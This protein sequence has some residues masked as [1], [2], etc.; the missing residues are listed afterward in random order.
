MTLPRRGRE[1][2]SQESNPCSGG[3]FCGVRKHDA[4][5]PQAYA[6]APS[7]SCGP[8]RRAFSCLSAASARGCRLRYGFGGDACCSDGCDQ[9]CRGSVVPSRGRTALSQ[10]CGF[11]R[12][13]KFDGWAAPASR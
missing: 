12:R 9:S 10:W 13:L 3:V 2:D 8:M 11:A 1:A 7:L 4:A 6:Y 5:T